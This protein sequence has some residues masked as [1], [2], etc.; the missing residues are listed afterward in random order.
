MHEIFGA[1][2]ATGAWSDQTE[3]KIAETDTRS[4]TP[5]HDNRD[6]KRWSYF[7]GKC[8]DSFRCRECDSGH[9]RT[10]QRYGYAPNLYLKPPRTRALE[11]GTPFLP[12]A[13]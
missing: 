5:T 4:S 2:D 6:V 1:T 7:G 10:T 9:F 13:H 3:R 12:H 11:I 8:S